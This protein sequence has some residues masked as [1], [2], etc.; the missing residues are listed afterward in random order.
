MH[1]Y[2]N[3]CIYSILLSIR[4]EQQQLS[5]ADA[6]AL[7]FRSLS[8]LEEHLAPRAYTH[9]ISDAADGYACSEEH[10]EDCNRAT[11]DTW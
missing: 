9:T 6:R 5:S 2:K 1:T 3:I 10:P 4:S 11:R 7:G 8:T